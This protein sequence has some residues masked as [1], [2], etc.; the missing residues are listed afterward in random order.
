MAHEVCAVK[1]S[2]VVTQVLVV[3]PNASWTH[4]NIHREALVSKSMSDD[5]KKG[6][7]I[8]VKI[9]N[10]IRSRPLQSRL[11]E[12]LCEEMRSNHKKPLSARTCD[13]IGMMFSNSS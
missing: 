1:K 6:L 10:L 11:F 3:S 12:E 7:I 5:L 4:C 13:I 2:G 8:A 9:V